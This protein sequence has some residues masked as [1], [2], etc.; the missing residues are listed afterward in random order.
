VRSER[1]SIV[2]RPLVLPL[3][4]MTAAGCASLPGST[5]EIRFDGDGFTVDGRH[6]SEVQPAADYLQRRQPSRIRIRGCGAESS[7]KLML[8]AA[9]VSS[10]FNGP[11]EVTMDLNDPDCAR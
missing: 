4:L 1:R 10:K 3:V 6:F 5:S 2:L 7:V 11:I 8:A 9:T